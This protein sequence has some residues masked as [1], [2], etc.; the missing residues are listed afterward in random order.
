MKPL[1]GFLNT[2]IVLSIPNVQIKYT[3]KNSLRLALLGYE[4]LQN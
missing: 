2:Y 1:N 3:Q 4:H